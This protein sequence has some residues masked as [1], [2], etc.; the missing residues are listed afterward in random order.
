MKPT[1]LRF[2]AGLSATLGC[3]ALVAGQGPPPPDDR[4]DF[5]YLSEARPVLVRMHVR[6]D[7]RPVQAAW[8]DF[9]QH[10][11]ASL[12]SN[13]DG[14]L[15]KDESDR[16]PSLEQILSGGLA[17]AFG[18][19]GMGKKGGT[20]PA[21]DAGQNKDGR[22]T[23]AELGELYRKGGFLPLQ[24]EPD[25][26]QNNPLG[27]A[28]I[29]GGR[30]PEPTVEAV[31]DGIFK[32]LD[33]DG[34]GKL[35]KDEL[36]AAPSI[37]LRRDEDDDEIVTA[38][39]IVEG[40]GMNLF[41]MGMMMNAG[42]DGK[43]AKGNKSLVPVPTPGEAP[44][45]LARR[46]HKRYGPKVES[47]DEAKKDEPVKLSRKDLGLDEA[48]F[49]KLDSNR[50]GVLDSTELAGFVKRAPD[51]ELSLNLG[52]GKNTKSPVEL[53]AP[54]GEPSPLAGKVRM[55]HGLVHLDL[56]RTRVDLRGSSS[57]QPDRISGLIRQQLMAQFKQADR[58]N[59]GYLDEAAAKNSAAFRD[60]F[61]AM[62]RDGD[63]KVYESEMVA[64]FD[65]LAELQ[66]RARLACVTLVLTNQS[67]GLFD[68]LDMDRDGRLSVRELRG[69]AK[70]L[71]AL[72]TG[73]KGYL[74]KSDLPRSYQLTL[75]R[76]PATSGA[77]GGQAAILALYSGG[78]ANDGPAERTEGPLWFRKMDRNRDGDV[79]RREFLGT[80]EQFRQIDAD[81]DG[82]ISADEADRFDARTRKGS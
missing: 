1:L 78:D 5:V 44:A 28:A 53:V 9:L 23:L 3:L 18:G 40:K 19:I 33:T 68:A 13:G 32:L 39:E 29:L 61:K 52:Y 63:G 10:V 21:A 50:D 70:L 55:R 71:E 75:R 49:A 34:D 25:A 69:A 11:F 64:Y 16:M 58:T 6:I 81:G 82:L 80:D 20:G 62:D 22:L 43:T 15:S 67:R 24:I 14:V 8:D 31:A 37:L 60:T 77:L 74:E 7:G 79:S 72:D 26:A 27:G 17:R 76:G 56:G 36:T 54:K 51:V 47:D 65:H 59:K 35:S 73:H 38:A 42:G 57:Y 30:R 4:H 46:L 12:D 66:R 2:M 45:D 41:A 48:T